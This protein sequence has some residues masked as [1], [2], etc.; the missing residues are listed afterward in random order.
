MNNLTL[1]QL[2]KYLD[3]L[4][5]QS[6]SNEEKLGAQSDS[7]ASKLERLVPDIIANQ[8]KAELYNN[9]IEQEPHGSA[10]DTMAL[11]IKQLKEKNKS[12]EKHK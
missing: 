9:I 2:P 11:K 8:E 5:Q 1:E 4:V 12:L 6:Y 10:L 3:M 7:V